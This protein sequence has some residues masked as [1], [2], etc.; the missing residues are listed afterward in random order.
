[1][2]PERRESAYRKER[3]EPLLARRLTSRNRLAS[4]LAA[5]TPPGWWPR[6]P[7]RVVGLRYH[8]TWLAGL[9]PLLA[10]G[11]LVCFVWVE[12]GEMKWIKKAS[13][14]LLVEKEIRD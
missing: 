7:L 1:L 11:L 5:R 8:C 2:S 12:Q 14:L 13:Y 4:V 6:R 3:A 9:T 10:L